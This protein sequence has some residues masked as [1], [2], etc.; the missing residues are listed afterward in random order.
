MI[1]YKQHIMDWLV[2]TGQAPNMFGEFYQ[3]TFKSSGICDF[4]IGYPDV[5]DAVKAVK[6]AGGFADLA[7]PGQ[8][9]NFGLIPKLVKCGLD[10]LEL[11]HP[12]NS[13]VDKDVIWDY[14]KEYG[15]FLTGGSDYHGK[16]EDKSAGIGD[17]LSEVSGVQAIC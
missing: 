8:Q 14:A 5:F 6:N 17:Y 16:Y 12:T 9:Q 13:E 7:H 3:N 1:I 10:G 11:N 15:L 2:S 4:D